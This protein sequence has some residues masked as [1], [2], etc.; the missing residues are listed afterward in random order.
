MTELLYMIKCIVKFC[1]P[2]P[3]LPTVRS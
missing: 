2:I 3:W 1:A